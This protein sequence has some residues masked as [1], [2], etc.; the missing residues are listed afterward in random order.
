MV[1]LLARLHAGKLVSPQAC[2]DMLAHMEACD[3]K[4]KF[5]ALLPPGIKLPHKTGSVARVRTDAGILETPSGPVALCVLTENNR[6]TSWS[7]DNAGNRLCAR[8]AKIVFDHFSA[9]DAAAETPA[10]SEP[11]TL[12]LGATGELV[13]ALQRTL[14][15]RSEPPAHLSVDGDFGPATQAAVRAFQRSK[16]LEASGEVNSATWEALGPLMLEAAP[17]PDPEL[18]NSEQLAQQPADDPAGPPAV[19]CKAWA[20]ADAASGEVLWHERGDQSAD[21]ASTTKIMTA[22]LVMRYCHEHPEALEEKIVFS[23]KADKTPGSTSGVRTGERVRVADLLYG[24]LL[25]SGNDASVAFAEHFGARLDSGQDGNEDQ[26]QASDQLFIAAMNRAAAE[27]KMAQTH[28]ANP[29]G[30]TADEHRSSCNDLV[31]L[32]V[33]ARQLPLFRQ[34]TG[35]RQY[36]CRV[37][38]EAGYERNL[39]WENTNRLLAI[40]GY[41]GIKTGSTDA[42][43]ACLVSA[44]MRGDR[45][46]IVV[47]LG[48]AASAARY[49]DTRNLYAW[50]WRQ[51]DDRP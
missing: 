30:L 38:G 28:F 49:S 17:V 24:L 47:V 29:H 13:E 46:L 40:D 39:K 25:P 45:E 1:D 7:E 26:Q 12:Q 20:I 48:S 43:G 32:T 15:A 22:L 21:I 37:T 35:C 51:L 34:V 16:H 10:P 27:L 42:A 33:A 8:I 3:D 23:E 2:R 9:G 6:D 36:G 50:A 11:T 4:L 18:V 31:R 19:T 41:T 44:A 14:N 5:P